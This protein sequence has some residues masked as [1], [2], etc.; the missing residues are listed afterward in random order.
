MTA[1]RLRAFAPA[2]VNL[3]LHVAPP[4][5]DGMHPVAS[6]MVFAD[7]GDILTAEPGGRG[8]TL[9]I[10]GRFAPDL[11]ELDPS[12]NLIVRAA[13]RL[14]E[15]MG[16]PEPD[17]VF[18]LDKALPTAAGLGGGSSD[19][20]AALRLTAQ[21]LGLSPDDPRLAQVAGE[22]GAD[23]PACLA[24]GPVLGLGRGDLLEPPPR[25]P[26]LHAVLVNSGA[27]SPTGGVYRAYDAAGAPGNAEPLALAD[28]LDGPAL[29]ARLAFGRND[30]ESPAAALTPAVAETLA[31]VMEQAEARLTRL[32]GSG[33]TVFALC[34]SQADAAQLA[35]RLGAFRPEWWVKVCR[36]GGPWPQ[37]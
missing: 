16:A 32:S 24:A 33:A 27:L 1:T 22:L 14:A 18:R 21:V 23:G 19:A 15:L 25:L 34:D 5:P 28:D 37:A 8:V 4:T 26:L 6:L 20:G 13:R 7:V 31:L 9:E 11:A 2:K 36:L 3:Y 17:V 12:R 35:T 10:G 30:L 29:A